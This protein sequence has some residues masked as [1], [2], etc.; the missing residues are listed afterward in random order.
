MSIQ[1]HIRNRLRR[2]GRGTV[3]SA[4]DFADIGSR[5][6]VDQALSRLPVPA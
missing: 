3:F 5:A 2:R 4:S 6:A 1:D